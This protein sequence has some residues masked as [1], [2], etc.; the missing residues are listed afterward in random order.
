MALLVW[1]YSATSSFVLGLLAGISATSE[2]LGGRPLGVDIMASR[3]RD[4]L[5]LDAAEIVEMHEGRRI[6]IDSRN[7]DGGTAVLAV[8]MK[9]R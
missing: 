2:D 3:Y 8:Q 9:M 7:R 6:P 4:D 1:K 5:C